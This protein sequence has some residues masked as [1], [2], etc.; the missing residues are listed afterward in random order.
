MWGKPGGGSSA[1]IAPD[2]TV[3]TTNLGPTE[4]GIVYAE[5]DHDLIALNKSFV[6]LVGHYS[7]PDLFTLVVDDRT[8]TQVVYLDD[9]GKTM[10]GDKV[11]KDKYRSGG[12][13]KKV[14]RDD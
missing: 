9:R 4:E 1:V 5:I 14:E 8:K 11:G 12:V 2:G 7:R 6:D 10:N 3:L 13:V